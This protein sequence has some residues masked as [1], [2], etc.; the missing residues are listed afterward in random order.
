MYNKLELLR[1]Q[2]KLHGIDIYIVPMVDQHNNEYVPIH[3]KRIAWI[4]GFTGSAGEL[5]V[6]KDQALLWTD[7]RYVLQAETEL[8]ATLFTLMRS[9]NTNG[10]TLYE[11]LK[12]N[13]TNKVVSVDPRLVTIYQFELLNN[14]LLT[15]NSGLTLENNNLIDIVRRDINDFVVP[16]FNSLYQLDIRY[17]GMNIETK[18]HV[19]QKYLN[20]M[21][22]DYFV[23][24]I[25]DVI[26]WIYNI[27]GSDILYNP[28]PLAYT[29]I[30]QDVSFLFV[31]DV[32]IDQKFIDTCKRLKIQLLKYDEFDIKLSSLRGSF[33]VD[34]KATNMWVHN[35]INVQCQIINNDLD[36]LL[37]KSVKNNTEI[38]GAYSAHLKD[39]VA[40]IKFFTW[41]EHNWKHGLTEL[42]CVDK[43]LQF[44][45]QQDNFV[46][47]S[48]NT[49]SGF[50]SNS[51]VI[52]YAV[53][54][55]TNKIVDNTNIFL[56]DSGGQYLE[57]TTD[58]TRT[59]HLGTPS[60]EQKY[61]YTLVLKGHLALTRLK[62][63]SGTKGENID[64]I[65]RYHL[66]QIYQNYHH[67][68]GHGVG[69]FLCVHEGPQRISQGSSGI[70]IL[71]GMIISNEPGYYIDN[72][73]GIRI[74]NLIVVK[75]D[76]SCDAKNSK[77]GKFYCFDTLT[78]VPYCKKLIDVTLLTEEEKQQIFNYYNTIKINMHN[79][80]TAIEF[81][82]LENEI[83]II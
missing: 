33:A 61:F 42:T 59:I 35:L 76:S 43:I 27:R 51:A 15:V 45:Q 4:S 73:F 41:L 70:P 79:K 2:M 36:L 26:A 71:P 28:L 32:E 66:W 40:V 62:F 63:P 34:F 83:N 10:H 75:G 18:L 6:T 72:E 81:E 82:W 68:T 48:F 12:L 30:S 38:S 9:D 37:L 20:D 64:I 5:V 13:A 52:H 69:S 49:I 31:N 44:R 7:G 53:N 47:N 1:N 39:G 3:W 77:Y 21:K 55:K 78:M 8:D 80:L 25:L 74:E 14:T 54:E 19:I 56:L 23:S 17:T 50:G 16:K 24:N 67:G 65:A 29:I 22:C 60:K 46:G 58:I 57:G 11:W